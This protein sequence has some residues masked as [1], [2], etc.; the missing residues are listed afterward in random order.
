MFG[1]FIKEPGMRCLICTHKIS[2]R[3][4]KFIKASRRA[5]ESVA[6]LCSTC[7]ISRNKVMT[8]MKGHK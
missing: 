5:G 6:E 4:K 1:L 2:K 7:V 3:D 8:K